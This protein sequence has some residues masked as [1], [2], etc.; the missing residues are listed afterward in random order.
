[1]A[2]G[3]S[4]P[5]KSIALDTPI[6]RCHSWRFSNALMII[7]KWA[8]HSYINKTESTLNGTE[9]MYPCC[10][11]SDFSLK[12]RT[13]FHAPGNHVAIS[14]CRCQHSRCFTSQ[15]ATGVLRA[16]CNGPKRACADEHLTTKTKLITVQI[17][18]NVPSFPGF[19]E[20]SQKVWFPAECPFS[21]KIAEFW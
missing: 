4:F 7:V 19:H 9:L 2:N 18:S 13:D 11:M 15:I 20:I 14:R 17:S 8:W 21:C 6:E 1:M 10:G 3:L 5:Y 16:F 12:E